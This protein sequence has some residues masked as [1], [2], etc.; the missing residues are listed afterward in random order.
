VLRQVRIR[1]PLRDDALQIVSARLLEESNAIA[2]DM[3][4][5]EQIWIAPWNKLA[6]PPPVNTDA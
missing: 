3:V 5:I 2:L 4:A 1:F 6:K